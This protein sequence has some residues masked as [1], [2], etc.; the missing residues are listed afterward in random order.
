MALSKICQIVGGY[1]L[2]VGTNGKD[3]VLMHA[4]GNFAVPNES[5]AQFVKIST[6][7]EKNV[8]RLQSKTLQLPFPNRDLLDFRQIQKAILH[9]RHSQVGNHDGVSGFD[10][11]TLCDTGL[12]FG[13]MTERLNFPICRYIAEF[14]LPQFDMICLIN[15]HRSVSEQMPHEAL[16]ELVGGGDD[17]LGGFLRPLHRAEDVG[18]GALLGK[19][20]TNNLLLLQDREVPIVP[21]ARNFDVGK[22]EIKKSWVEFPCLWDQNL[23][24]IGTGK[25]GEI[26]K[27]ENASMIT[28]D[29]HR[30]VTRVNAFVLVGVSGDELLALIN[31]G[32][33]TFW[34]V[35]GRLYFSYLYP[36]SKH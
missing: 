1:S 10:F 25:K 12:D 28:E 4:S 9:V 19:R 27:L 21:S 5:T 30:Q 6:F 26:H 17:L 22:G 11:P 3:V 31:N 2:P 20:R 18:D 16:L 7:S 36:T 23:S 14:C 34:K 13:T 35:I 29:N 33:L 15:R 8:A 32:M 24:S